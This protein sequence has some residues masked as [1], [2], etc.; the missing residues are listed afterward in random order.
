MHIP[1]VANL[2]MILFLVVYICIWT[3][4]RNSDSAWSFF[5]GTVFTLAILCIFQDSFGKSGWIEF[6]QTYF[7]EPNWFFYIIYIFMLFLSLPRLILDLINK[8]S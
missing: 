3:I 7:I 1:L 5:R 2:A 6:T 8:H 4:G